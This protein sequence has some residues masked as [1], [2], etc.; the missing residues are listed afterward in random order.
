MAITVDE[1]RQFERLLHRAE[2]DR[3]YGTL[4]RDDAHAVAPL[5]LELEGRGLTIP[6]ERSDLAAAAI[7]AFRAH[8]ATMTALMRGR[9]IHAAV[10]DA[11]AL[12]DSALAAIIV[13]DVLDRLAAAPKAEAKEDEAAGPAAITFTFALDA[14]AKKEIQS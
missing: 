2:L 10:I 9:D 6:G 11:A 8:A 5:L 4:F 12:L 7:V 3:E 14:P 13:G 1:F